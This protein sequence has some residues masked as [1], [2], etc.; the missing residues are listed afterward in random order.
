MQWNALHEYAEEA[1][2]W[3]TLAINFWIIATGI[4]FVIARATNAS[5]PLASQLTSVAIG[6][7]T[8][9]MLI[10]TV[11]GVVDVAMNPNFL[12]SGDPYA[13]AIVTLGLIASYIL[14]VLHRR[15][16]N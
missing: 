7:F 11:F 2:L 6:G 12:R 4:F 8:A 5:R 3:T 13:V 1:E 15:N 10:L 9:S 16:S 14:R